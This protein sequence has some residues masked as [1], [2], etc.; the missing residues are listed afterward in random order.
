MDHTIE[1]P[2]LGRRQKRN[3]RIE[4]DWDSSSAAALLDEVKQLRAAL[5]VFQE[6][7]RRLSIRQTA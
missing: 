5:A 3:N 4:T 7:A 2:N 1:V 6:I